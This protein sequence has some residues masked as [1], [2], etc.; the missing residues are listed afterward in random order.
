MFFVPA[1]QLLTAG[2]TPAKEAEQVGAGHPL[3]LAVLVSAN[4]R[5]GGQRA[6][7]LSFSLENGYAEMGGGGGPTHPAG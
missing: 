6:G 3:L 4:G 2:G 5:R 1:A 7:S